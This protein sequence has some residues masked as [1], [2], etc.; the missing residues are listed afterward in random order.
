[1][2]IEQEI[3]R[4]AG[5]AV[6]TQNVL[7]GIC[8]GL[9]HSGDAGEFIVR[10]AFDYAEATSA[11]ASLKLGADHHPAHMAAMANVIEQI[12]RAALGDNGGPKAAV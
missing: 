7:V 9:A 8:M 3:W 4:L 12:R 6:A 2:D 10:T 5:E 11:A 1:M